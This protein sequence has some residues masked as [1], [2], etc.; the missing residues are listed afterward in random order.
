MSYSQVSYLISKTCGILPDL[1]LLFLTYYHRVK[2]H[3]LYD[4]GYLL[5][6]FKIY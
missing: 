3:A 1:L 6:P 5:S 2:E 4:F